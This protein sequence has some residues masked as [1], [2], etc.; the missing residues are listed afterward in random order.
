MGRGTVGGNVMKRMSLSLLVLVVLCAC[1]APPSPVP[2]TV[3]AEK[4]PNRVLDV[5]YLPEIQ[6]FDINRKR[7]YYT[8]VNFWYEFSRHD[9]TNYMRGQLVPVNSRVNVLAVFGLR[10]SEHLKSGHR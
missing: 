1:A 10:L 4:D 8:R 2:D 6:P 5:D 7:I 9:T 3:A